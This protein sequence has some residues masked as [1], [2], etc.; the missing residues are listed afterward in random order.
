MKALP[1]LIL[2]FLFAGSTAR[3]QDDSEADA[4]NIAEASHKAEI[5]K[6]RKYLDFKEAFMEALKYKAT[7]DYERALEFLDKGE[8]LFP[9]NNSLLFEKAKVLFKL[10]RRDE[11][12]NYCQKLLT[13]KPGFFWGLA[14]LRDIYEKEKNY[15]EAL[16]IENKLYLIDNQE[17]GKL[18]RYYYIVRD[19]AA[20]KKLLREIDQKN[21]YVARI[22]FYKRYFNTKT[23]HQPAKTLTEPTENKANTTAPVTGNYR[24]ICEKL[25]DALQ[26]GDI[27]S[28]RINSEN[29]LELFPAQALIYWYNA[30]AYLKLNNTRKAIGLLEEGLDYI[31]D[32]QDLLKKFY[33][34]LA[35]A[36]RTI[37]NTKKMNYYQNKARKL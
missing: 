10:E 25:E 32:N 8:A 29:A 21:I 15:K 20:G 36:F 35:E 17:A 16:K 5:K 11:A 33:Q 22:D 23:T 37:H 34:S 3:A 31:V 2:F 6:E 14:L 12:K 27:K 9:E 28:L 24:Q 26:K 1:V 30:Q 7:E 13:Q 4:A 18:L 19:K